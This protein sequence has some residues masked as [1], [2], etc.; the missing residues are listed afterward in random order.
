MMAVRNVATHEAEDDDEQRALEQLAALSVLAR[1]IDEA[2][3][4]T[5]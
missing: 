4:V 3:V 2:D 1:W 5:A